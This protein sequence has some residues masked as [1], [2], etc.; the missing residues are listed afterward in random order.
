[1]GPWGFALRP[2]VG[3]TENRHP[4]PLPM[5]PILHPSEC[6]LGAYELPRGIEQLR[7]RFLGP[8]LNPL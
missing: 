2:V 5:I 1:M 3:T 4:L 8:S 7:L 6:A